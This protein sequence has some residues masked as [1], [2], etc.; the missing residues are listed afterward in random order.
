MLLSCVSYSF[1]GQKFYVSR[2]GKEDFLR[3]LQSEGVFL[4]DAIYD[5][6]NQIKDKKVRRSK[7]QAHYQ[8]LKKNIGTLLL[9]DNAKMLLIHGN[10]IKAIGQRLRTDFQKDGYTF[11]EIG[12]PSYYNDENFRAKIKR[13]IKD[14]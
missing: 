6:I 12:F 1:L 5:P 7:I 3:K 13:A 2:D 14:G 4:L 10:V 8:Q 9:L 11:Y